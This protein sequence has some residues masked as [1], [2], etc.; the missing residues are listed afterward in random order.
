MNTARKFLVRLEQL[1]FYVMVRIPARSGF[2]IFLIIISALI[3]NVSLLAN[4][5]NVTIV[6]VV[7]SR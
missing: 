7:P 3:L 6:F 5:T 1:T 4:N 2:I